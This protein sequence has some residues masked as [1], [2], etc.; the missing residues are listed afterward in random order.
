MKTSST[1]FLLL[2]PSRFA[3]FDL[4]PA[5]PFFQGFVPDENRSED[6]GFCGPKEGH[7]LSLTRGR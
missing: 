4:I 6:D 7:V 5:F 3:E 2:P 1:G